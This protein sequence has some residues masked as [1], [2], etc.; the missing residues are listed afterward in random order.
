[1]ASFIDPRQVLG[2]NVWVKPT[3]FAVALS[4]YLGSL[5]YFA[6]WLPDRLRINVIYRAY[7]ICIVAAVIAEFVWITGAAA[8]ATQS[9][10]NSELP[11]LVRLY[12]WMGILAIFLTSASIFYGLQI[13][14]NIGPG[15]APAERVALS[16]GLILTF[17][18]TVLVA[19]Y[20][21]SNGGHHVGLTGS[22]ALTVPVLGWSRE[23]GDLRV[24][25]FF[26]THAM[27]AVPIIRVAL[28]R[29]LPRCA[30]L[31]LTVLALA[32][33]AGFIAFT[34]LQARAGLPFI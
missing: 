21:S 29:I 15:M 2:Q 17:V 22:G 30:V 6:R 18:S 34:F 33:Y 16:G 3:K 24:A 9:H 27:Q 20:L 19:G 12:P 8:Y 5:A 28:Q 31:P 1:M 10:F 7:S 14:F 23:V 25:H 11:F 26:A 13:A 4:V 32:S